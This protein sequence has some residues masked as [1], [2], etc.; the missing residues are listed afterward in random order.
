MIALIC[1]VVKFIVDGIPG[2]YNLCSSCDE[3]CGEVVEEVNATDVFVVRA[4]TW[5]K[6]VSLG[7]R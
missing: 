1:L 7:L 3:C 5:V 4:W 6:D 2:A